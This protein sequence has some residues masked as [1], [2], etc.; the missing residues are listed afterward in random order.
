MLST[1]QKNQKG[2][3]ALI[4]ILII[5]GVTLLV[6]ISAN[7]LGIS[8]ADMGLQKN[9]SSR[10]FYLAVLCAE[11]ALMKLRDNLEYPGNE[12][13]VIGDGTC[14]ILPVEGSGNQNRVIKTTGTI[15]NQTRK[16]KIQINKVNPKM[17]I[18]S[19]QEVV[20]F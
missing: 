17:R 1:S 11:D 15:F 5:S 6:A 7:L 3:I 12:V 9:Q 4:S 16:I 10:S 18:N 13:L 14:N 8:E 19:W 2:Y 20:D